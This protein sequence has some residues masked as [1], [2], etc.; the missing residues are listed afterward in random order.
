MVNEEAHDLW[1]VLSEQTCVTYYFQSLVQIELLHLQRGYWKRQWRMPKYMVSKLHPSSSWKSQNT[2]CS[3][4]QVDLWICKVLIKT[5][6]K[7]FER[8]FFVT[9]IKPCDLMVNQALRASS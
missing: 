3:L 4:L 7:I 9:K 2:F 8:N 6:E 5:I 1:V